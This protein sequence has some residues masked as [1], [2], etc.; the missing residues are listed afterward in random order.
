MRQSKR[1]TN[2]D[3]NFSLR[4]RKNLVSQSRTNSEFP[5][6]PSPPRSSPPSLLCLFLLPSS[7]S[8]RYIH[9]RFEAIRGVRGYYTWDRQKRRLLGE[10]EEENEIKINSNSFRAR[11]KF[12]FDVR[13]ERDVS[14]SMQYFVFF[15]FS[16]HLQL[17]LSM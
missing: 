17:Q 11:H 10:H 3:C 16:P 1:S 15:S 7:S 8:N 5:P 9:F 14:P 12:Q 2:L 6:L 13:I 4:F